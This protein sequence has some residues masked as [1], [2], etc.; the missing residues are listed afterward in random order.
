MAEEQREENARR[1]AQSRME[2]E[3]EVH[4]VSAFMLDEHQAFMLEEE[5]HHVPAFTLNEHQEFMLDEEVHHVTAFTLDEHQVFTIDEHQAFTL[6]AIDKNL[7][8]VHKRAATLEALNPRCKQPRTAGSRQTA[9]A[10]MVL[11]DVPPAFVFHEDADCLDDATVQA[12]I[13]S[14][15][16]LDDATVQA[17]ID[18]GRF[19]SDA[20]EANTGVLLYDS[21][22]EEI[23][24]GSMDTGATECR[25]Y[26]VR[27]AKKKRAYARIKQPDEFYDLHVK[28][29]ETEGEVLLAKFAG[30]PVKL[31]ERKLLYVNG[32]GTCLINSFGAF[33][34]N[35][36]FSG[37]KYGDEFFN[38]RAFH[39]HMLQCRQ[40][41]AKVVK[42]NQKFWDSWTSSA[43]YAIIQGPP[44]YT[45][46]ETHKR[47]QNASKYC[48]L[49]DVWLIVQLLDEVGFPDP[50]TG[51][52][53]RFSLSLKLYTHRMGTDTHGKPTAH[54]TEQL[55]EPP[56]ATEMQ[57]QTTF[58][59]VFNVNNEGHF[60]YCPEYE[61]YEHRM[62]FETKK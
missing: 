36:L 52:L 23:F 54:C 35:I 5:V 38:Y 56:N 47:L 13:D 40:F 19:G 33:L 48:E 26:D 41:V 4:H 30:T 55:V 7:Q 50:D 16:F 15:R 9:H 17:M 42:N 60:W 39:D 21:D 25:I 61:Q 12:M 8:H 32:T 14:G 31:A 49:G 18:S 20:N 45:R 11:D 46:E 6:K 34:V 27:N 59:G 37:E 10:Q 3:E 2:V 53:H 1:L 62:R 28:L 51:E 44:E 57:G 29:N 24:R 43:T 22:V 58:T